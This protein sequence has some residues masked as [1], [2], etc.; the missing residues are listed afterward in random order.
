M[1]EKFTYTT[2]PNSLRTFIKGIPDRSKPDKV[3]VKYLKQ[4]GF[5]SSND[6]TIIKVLKFIDFLDS[7]GAPTEAYT[8][9][10]NKDKGPAVMADQISKAYAELFK[11]YPAPHLQSDSAL[12]N[13]FRESTGLAAKTVNLMAATFKVLCEYADFSKQSGTPLRQDPGAR[14]GTSQTGTQIHLNIQVVLPSNAQPSEYDAIFESL[15][16]HLKKLT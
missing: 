12:Q 2:V 9:Y 8:Q 11:V 3:T 6:A 15:A 7:P 16:K 4:I 10:L 1:A 14:S 5:K 13:F